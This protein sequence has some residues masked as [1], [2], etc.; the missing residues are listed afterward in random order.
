M[1]LFKYDSYR[2]VI[3]EEAL[4]LKPFKTI[5]NR[6]R[7]N[8]KD[9]ALQELG[10]IYFMCDPRSDYQYLVDESERSEAI[11]Q[12]EGMS[13]SWKPD[14][15][16]K[17]A[18]QFY[19]SFKTTSILLLE[20]T[21]TMIEGYRKKLKSIT[22]N[23]EDLDVKEI[24]ALGD[25]IKLIPTLVKD[26]DAAEKSVNAELKSSDGKVRGQKEKSLFENGIL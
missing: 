13:K 20:D 11:I 4:V 17:E 8:S 23:M 2:I 10:Y 14:K 18:M 1:K 24:K 15:V 16:V 6:D 12:G 25:I 5:W 21:R 7:S 9:K 19:T 22:S 26:L 3:S